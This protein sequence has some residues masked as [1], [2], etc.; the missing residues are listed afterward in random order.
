MSF[1][2]HHS[3]PSQLLWEQTLTDSRQQLL[4]DQ[5]NTRVQRVVAYN[6][7]VVRSQKHSSHNL[8]TYSFKS[9]VRK[10]QLALHLPTS[11][12]LKSR[13][14]VYLAASEDLLGQAHMFLLE[15]D[16]DIPFHHLK[17]ALNRYLNTW[18]MSL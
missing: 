18:R 2:D 13:S 4:E 16:T 17:H 5:S 10:G 3:L 7:P 11:L 8:R 1:I 9:V 14:E 12:L 15:F 6:K